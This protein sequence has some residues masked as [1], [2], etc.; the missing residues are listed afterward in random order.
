MKLEKALGECKPAPRVD[1]WHTPLSCEINKVI[2]VSLI[3]KLVPSHIHGKFCFSRSVVQLSTPQPPQKNK[4]NNRLANDMNECVTHQ[5][6]E[7]DRFTSSN[8]GLRLESMSTSKPYS[9]AEGKH[10]RIRVRREKSAQLE[11]P[12][13]RSEKIKDEGYRSH[14]C[15]QGFIAA[16]LHVALG[17][18]ARASFCYSLHAC[19]IPNHS[20]KRR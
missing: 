11:T 9:S 14:Q 6:R 13:I 4:K 15:F 10:K 1:C 19:Y 12:L 2:L 5:A 18:A 17:V 20:R 16:P 8:Q 3:S 7:G